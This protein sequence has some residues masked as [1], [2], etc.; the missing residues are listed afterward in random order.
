M[1]HL[2]ILAQAGSDQSNVI[3]PEPLDQGQT[4]T[5]VAQDDPGQDANGDVQPGQRQGFDPM[6]LIFFAAIILMM[7]FLLFRGPKK[8]Q[9]EHQKMVQ[10]LQKNDRI[11]TIGGIIGTIVDIKDDHMVIKIDESTNTKIKISPNA[12]A[13]NLSKETK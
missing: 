10:S 8:R 9:Q 4:E 2:W 3:L 7:Y 12:I 6:Q 11:R 13:D 5:V 1:N